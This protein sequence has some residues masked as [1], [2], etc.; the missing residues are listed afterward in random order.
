MTTDPGQITDR[1]YS[2]N[3]EVPCPNPGWENGTIY[4]QTDDGKSAIWE[5]G[6]EYT[7]DNSDEPAPS[8][9]TH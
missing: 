2:D 3:G 6:H 7:K 4:Y 1:G 5:N 9:W 8:H